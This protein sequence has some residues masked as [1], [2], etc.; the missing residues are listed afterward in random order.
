MILLEAW[1]A[2]WGQEPFRQGYLKSDVQKVVQVGDCPGVQ[3]CKL[4]RQSIQ[5]RVSVVVCLEVFD[6]SL[7]VGDLSRNFEVFSDLDSNRDD[8]LDCEL[9]C[10]HF[11]TGKWV[12]NVHVN[13]SSQFSNALGT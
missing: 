13:Q 1:L 10:V 12:L 8:H 5:S 11:P 2:H 4:R 6:V 7:E 9:D 3:E